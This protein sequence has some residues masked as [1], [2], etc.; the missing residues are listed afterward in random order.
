ML[1]ARKIIIPSLLP[2]LFVTA[3]VYDK[4]LE[5]NIAWYLSIAMFGITTAVPVGLA[6]WYGWELRKEFANE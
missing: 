1:I 3:W 2:L 5:A 6:I 4:F